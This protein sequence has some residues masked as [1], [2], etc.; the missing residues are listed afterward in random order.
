MATAYRGPQ[1]NLLPTK[2]ISWQTLATSYGIELAFILLLVNI[3]L[4]FPEKL[5][6]KT[7]YHLTQLVPLRGVEPKPLPKPKPQMVRAKLL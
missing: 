3:G 7:S 4:L 1:F 6:V 2:R 5:Q